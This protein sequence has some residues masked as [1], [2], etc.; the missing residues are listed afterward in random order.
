M[1]QLLLGNLNVTVIRFKEITEGKYPLALPEDV[2]H[3]PAILR[4]EVNSA[5]KRLLQSEI[6]ESTG[7]R[8][9]NKKERKRDARKRLNASLESAGS[10]DNS[11]YINDVDLLEHV[12]DN[13]M[14]YLED[15]VNDKL[16]VG[17]AKEETAKMN[18]DESDGIASPSKQKKKQKSKK[19]KWKTMVEVEADDNSDGKSAPT[20]RSSPNDSS[21]QQEEVILIKRAKLSKRSSL[22]SNAESQ[23]KIR[24]LSEL[25]TP[26]NSVSMNSS[27]SKSSSRRVSFVLA[28]NLEHGIKVFVNLKFFYL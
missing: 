7:K 24:R 11:Q 17:E 2:A 4:K 1:Y 13:Y 5:A 6:N 16:A 3:K 15:E 9:K 19:R 10:E 20:S 18:V 21:N 28:R 12:T 26:K 23:R 25:R 8:R 14:S 27:D 22:G